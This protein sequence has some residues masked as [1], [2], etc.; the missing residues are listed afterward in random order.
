MRRGGIGSGAPQVF[1]TLWGKID[2]CTPLNN[3]RCE[4]PVLI[5]EKCFITSEHS[6]SFQGA[7]LLVPRSLQSSSEIYWILFRRSAFYSAAV[8]LFSWPI[9]F[10]SPIL[11]GCFLALIHLFT[12]TYLLSPCTFFCHGTPDIWPFRRFP[13]SVSISILF[14]VGVLHFFSHSRYKPFLDFQS[15]YSS[16]LPRHSSMFSSHSSLSSLTISPGFPHPLPFNYDHC[17]PFL[18]RY[19]L[20]PLSSPLFQQYVPPSL[21]CTSLRIPAHQAL[22]RTRPPFCRLPSSSSH[23]YSTAT[24]APPP[25]TFYRPTDAGPIPVLNQC[26]SHY[27]RSIF[28]FFRSFWYDILHFHFFTHVITYAKSMSKETR[29]RKVLSIKINT[30]K[31]FHIWRGAFSLQYFQIYSTHCPVFWSGPI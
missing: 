24:P 19:Q 5:I 8:V 2:W 27:S 10:L 9:N 16:I 13:A 28:R 1:E 4:D 22:H 7:I 6:S 23:L 21:N 25:T 18:S 20:S 30:L 26:S 3:L 11:I 12:L 29:L 31:M 17:S 14:V 15:T